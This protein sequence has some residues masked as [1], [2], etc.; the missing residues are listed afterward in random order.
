MVLLRTNAQKAKRDMELEEQVLRERE[1]LQRELEAREEKWMNYREREADS[2]CSQFASDVAE[3]GNSVYSSDEGAAGR[4]E[5]EYD[6][7]PDY[8]SQARASEMAEAL[9]DGGFVNEAGR[10]CHCIFDEGF[11]C[12]L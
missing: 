10:L 3:L 1:M 11:D 2:D 4:D 7:N 8:L 5:S 9:V 6:P 12:S